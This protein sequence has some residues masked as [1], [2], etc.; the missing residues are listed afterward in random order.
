MVTPDSYETFGRKLVELYNRGY[1]FALLQ[2][3]NPED[4]EDLLGTALWKLLETY[5]RKPFAVGNYRNLLCRVII[6]C[7]LSKARYDNCRSVAER[8]DAGEDKVIPQQLRIE[9]VREA[10]DEMSFQQTTRRAT[11]VLPPKF[12]RVFMLRAIVGKSI[13]ETAQ[14]LGIPEG[15]VKSRY[16]RAARVLREYFAENPEELHALFYK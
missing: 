7:R 10:L 12:A 6:N 13:A 11:L 1:S 3:K 9:P 5:R 4:A 16:N 2:A 14:N 8:L 15:T